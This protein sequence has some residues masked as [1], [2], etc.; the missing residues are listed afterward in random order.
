[1]VPEREAADDRRKQP[2]CRSVPSVPQCAAGTLR[3]TGV[4]AR[5]EHIDFHPPAWRAW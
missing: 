1:M 5:Q 4:D 3:H 2:R